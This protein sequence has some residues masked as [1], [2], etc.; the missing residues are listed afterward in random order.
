MITACS[1]AG[2]F[3]GGTEQADAECV[4]KSVAHSLQVPGLT[5]LD[6]MQTGWGGLPGLWGPVRKTEMG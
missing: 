5:S 1:K 2:P 4:H 6:I 3:S